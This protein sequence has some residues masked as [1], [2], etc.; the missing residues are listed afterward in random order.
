M[1]ALEQYIHW[2]DESSQRK[3]RLYFPELDLTLY[4]D[5]IEA[6][7]FELTESLQSGDNLEFIGCIA[8]VMSV[9]V[10]GV[11][12]DL[13]DKKVEVYVAPY[14]GDEE[15]PL[16]KGKVDSA[17]K[18]SNKD[19]KLITA[20]DKLYELSQLDITA[21]YNHRLKTTIEDMFYDLMEYLEIEVGNVSFTNGHLLAYGIEAPVDSISALELLKSICQVNAVFGR[22]NRYGQ[23]ETITLNPDTASNLDISAHEYLDYEE[24]AVKPITRVIIRGYAGDEESVFSGEDA[25]NNY[26]IEGNIFAEDWSN[27]EKTTAATNIYNL[28]S[29]FSFIPYEADT[30]GCPYMEIGDTITLTDMERNSEGIKEPTTKKFIILQRTLSDVNSMRDN[31]VAEG[32]E[33][34]SEFSSNI[35]AAGSIS[36]SQMANYSLVRYLYRNSTKTMTCKDSEIKLFSI[37]YSSNLKHPFLLASVSAWLTPDE[38]TDLATVKIDG[39]ESQLEYPSIAH[40]IVNFRLV[41]NGEEIEYTHTNSFHKEGGFVFDIFYPFADLGTSAGVIEVYVSTQSG[42]FRSY[43]NG[44]VAALYGQGKAK[45]EEWDGRIVVMDYVPQGIPISQIKMGTSIVENI[46]VNT[47]KPIGG[48]V[49]TEITPIPISTIKI[50]TRISESVEFGYVV[51]SGTKSV[52][53]LDDW[54]YNPDYV[55]TG[56]S[57]F[58]MRTIYSFTATEETIDSGR[59]SVMKIVTEDKA[60]VESVVVR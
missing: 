41:L 17:P 55:N 25:T 45:G 34:Y 50:A 47:Q 22:I 5:S 53:N 30:R 46:S 18:E 60:S 48:A 28:V 36:N 27:D 37:S 43:E 23:F 4:N 57:A 9:S 33:L 15:I 6:E 8:S 58:G 12:T 54:E 10:H 3:M 16:F 56:N 7:T 38:S 20:Y 44:I 31:F 40:M 39:V 42:L 49:S 11:T 59:M 2:N 14:E 51:K 35:S 29:A 24:Y 21:W 26:I 19:F 52:D 13:V 32:A 1:I